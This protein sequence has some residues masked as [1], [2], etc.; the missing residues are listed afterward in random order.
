MF[1]EIR[2]KN[3][4]THVDT[5][6]Q[7][8]PI[9]LLIGPNNAGKTNFLAG[10]SHFARL[11]SRGRPGQNLPHKLKAGDFFPHR[12]RLASGNAPMIFS[13]KWTHKLGDVEYQLELQE[14]ERHEQNVGC[15]ERICMNSR[16]LGKSLERESGQDDLNDALK[17]QATVQSAN[18]EKEYKDLADHFF[19]DL[20]GSHL[21]QFQPSFL[22][23]SVKREETWSDPERLRI[24]SQIGSKGE[25]LQTILHLVK[26][27]E[28]RTYNGFVASLRRFEPSFH[29]LAYDEERRQ[30][31]W[32]FDLGHV[33][34]R[35]EEFPPQAV[36]DGLLRAAAI[37]LL[38]S[39]RRPPALLMIEEIE[40]GIS[41]RNLGRFWSWLQQA[42]GLP[43]STDRGYNTQ[44]LLTSHSPSILLEISKHLDDVFYMRLER[45]GYKSVV[46]NLNSALLGFVDL[47]TVEGEVEKRDGKDVVI[48][49][50][51]DLMNLWYSGIIGGEPA[52]EHRR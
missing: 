1:K 8:G 13:C 24:A 28:E 36:S 25:N 12:H 29:G 45:R 2:V 40:N 32:L 15:R 27:R 16:N 26:Q 44:F 7:L 52:N 5:T 38:S 42:A 43:D 30:A 10:I 11:I 39:M 22:N 41:Q 6:L 20:G 4:R 14:D 19:R 9:T 18:I 33:P 35:T 51:Q 23:D 31:V 49:S 47:G 50:P 21:F 3:F 17:L 34:P 46:R 37:A 48:L